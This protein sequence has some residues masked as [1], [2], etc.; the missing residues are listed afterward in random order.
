[1]RNLS[2]NL[3][4]W[5]L[6]YAN[7]K[8]HDFSSFLHVFSKK[9]F[10]FAKM[11]QMLA[12]WIVHIWMIFVQNACKVVRW[13][14]LDQ[15][16]AFLHFVS[17]YEHFTSIY[18]HMYDTNKSVIFLWH[19]RF[20]HTYMLVLARGMLGDAHKMHTCKVWCK[21]YSTHFLPNQLDKYSLR[22]RILNS[23]QIFHRMLFCGR[24]RQKPK[25]SF[26]IFSFP[27][28][29]VLFIRNWIVLVCWCENSWKNIIK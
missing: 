29:K 14:A 18:E 10:N 19:F 20:C 23:T 7:L 22:T 4:K 12:Y 15:Y 24:F 5:I 2:C 3:D 13:I 9:M 8:I 16:F 25:S 28:Q 27:D 6:K 11:Q 1:M 17:I 26:K 21:G